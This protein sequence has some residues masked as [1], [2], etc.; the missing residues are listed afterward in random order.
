MMRSQTNKEAKTQ[1]VCLD[2]MITLQDMLEKLVWIFFF[3][4]S[5]YDGLNYNKSDSL[6][7]CEEANDYALQPPFKSPGVECFMLKRL[8]LREVS[9]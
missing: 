2:E 5:G 7:L 8:A 3:I 6:V 9:L 1:H 4:Y